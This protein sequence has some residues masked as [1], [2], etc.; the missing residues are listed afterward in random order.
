[1][2]VEMR[3][4]AAKLRELLV[5]RPMAL[6]EGFEQLVIFAL[7]FIVAA[8]VA[9]A[10]VQLFEQTLPLVMRGTLNLLDRAA[11]DTLFSDIF[12]LIIALEFRHSISRT[13]NGRDHIVQV[14][15][16]VLI[17]LLAISRKFV[18]LDTAKS[19]AATI[20][21]LAAVTLVLG[22]VYWLLRADQAHPRPPVEGR[23]AV[24]E[25]R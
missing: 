25:K 15:T 19:S 6:F 18:I 23:L 22:A 16:V 13:G 24:D 7:N 2:G 10:L 1:M 11:F 12:T 9:I 8:I 5:R 21:A 4:F 3:R 17:A 20:A 14:R